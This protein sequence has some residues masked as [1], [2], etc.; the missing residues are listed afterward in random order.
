MVA[1]ATVQDLVSGDEIIS[2]SYDLK[3]IDDVVYEIDCKKVNKGGDDNFGLPL[4]HARAPA[5]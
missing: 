5:R 2:D 4:P 3:E 1:D